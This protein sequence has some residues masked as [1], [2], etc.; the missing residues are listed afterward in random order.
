MGGEEIVEGVYREHLAVEDT[1]KVGG[2]AVRG[3]LERGG[4]GLEGLEFERGDGAVG[5]AAGDDPVEVA[6]VG[7]DVEG[8]AV[9]GD[10]LGDV[11]ADGGD[12]FLVYA[13][14]GESPDA[15][16][17]ADA[18]SG[19]AEVFAG[20]DEDFLHQPDKIYR[21]Q[22]GTAFAGKVAAEV[23]DGVAD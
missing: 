23:E 2:D 21:S 8:E 16:E 10:R 18:L 7:G 4:R 3:L 13:A 22:M 17:F 12:L 9:R 20:V 11:D 1:A 15:G 19:D 6:D 5:D 14:A